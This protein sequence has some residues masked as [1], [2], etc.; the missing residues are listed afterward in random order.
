MWRGF[1]CTS[2]GS[3]LEGN[4]EWESLTESFGNHSQSNWIILNHSVLLNL[5]DLLNLRSLWICLKSLSSDVNAD[6]KKMFWSI[7]LFILGLTFPE[8]FVN[9]YINVYILL[10][11]FCTFPFYLIFCSVF[12]SFPFHLFPL[13]GLHHDGKRPIFQLGQWRSSLLSP[14]QLV[15]SDFCSG[16][17]L[18]AQT[19]I[20]S[21]FPLPTVVQLCVLIYRL[22]FEGWEEKQLGEHVTFNLSWTPF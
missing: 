21:F 19:D 17:C 4:M 10:C 6:H 15:A 9:V 14:S 1:V 8:W 11:I 22:K 5:W 16:S 12:I 18:L 2:P 13:F 7:C 20:L 3:V